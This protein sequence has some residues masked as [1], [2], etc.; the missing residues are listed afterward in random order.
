MVLIFGLG[1][2][3]FEFEFEFAVGLERI[4]PIERANVRTHEQTNIPWTTLR[5]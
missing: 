3:E 2:F 4:Q 1:S 5:N